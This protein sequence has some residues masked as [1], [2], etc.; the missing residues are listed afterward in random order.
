[1]SSV[2][3]NWCI[4]CNYCAKLISVRGQKNPTNYYTYL[5]VYRFVPLHLEL[6][7]A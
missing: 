6:F 7:V 3:Q 5:L 4:I 1:M 2:S